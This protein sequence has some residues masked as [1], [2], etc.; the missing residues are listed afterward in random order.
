[1]ATVDLTTI[2]TLTNQISA[3][4]AQAT[5]ATD[6]TVKAMLQSQIAVAESQLQAEAQHQQSQVDASNNLLSNL[7]LFATLS[8]TVGSVAP[9]IVA[10]FSK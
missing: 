10:L 6:P 9:S 8:N 3:L 5:A 2:V 1:M 7:G 4:Q